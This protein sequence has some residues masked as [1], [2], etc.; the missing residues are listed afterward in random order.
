MNPEVLGVLNST[1]SAIK[2]GVLRIRCFARD[3]YTIS[4]RYF[5]LGNNQCSFS[6]TFSATGYMEVALPAPGEYTISNVSKKETAFKNGVNIDRVVTLN[7]GE[8]KQVDA[9]LSTNCWEGVK[10]I[11]DNH[12]EKKLPIGKKDAFPQIVIPADTVS[13]VTTGIASETTFDVMAYTCDN[14]PHYPHS[15]VF[16]FAQAIPGVPTINATGDPSRAGGAGNTKVPKGRGT[17][18]GNTGVIYDFTNT[19]IVGWLYK[20]CDKFD[21]CS[22]TAEVS[23]PWTW[24]T[25]ENPNPSTAS[26]DRLTPFTYLYHNLPDDLKAI[27]TPRIF[28][29]M[30][31]KKM[32]I[33][34]M[35]VQWGARSM[36]ETIDNASTTAYTAG[37]PNV[38]EQCEDQRYGLPL[39]LART[40][41]VGRYQNGASIREYFDAR[42]FQYFE[43]DFTHV[44]DTTVLTDRGGQP[45][46]WWTGSP[47]TSNSTGFAYIPKTGLTGWKTS[48]TILSQSV[49]MNQAKASQYGYLPFFLVAA[50]DSEFS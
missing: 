26:Y 17:V 44:T 41:E 5:N 23:M 45:V 31:G 27:I 2:Y 29:T 13:S 15:V 40:Y 34:P 46:C 48:K 12:F 33:P 4:G 38:V 30:P 36:I 37:K 1:L 39:W 7:S 6:K 18:A 35:S 43:Q 10:A 11:I 14:V 9:R 25:G 22:A 28:T 32:A 24:T 19:S 49:L 47:S 16:G 21:V 20:E 3:T 42:P 8:Y 50:N